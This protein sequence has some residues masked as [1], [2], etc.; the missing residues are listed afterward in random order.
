M[1][2]FQW[3]SDIHSTGIDDIDAQH[4]KLFDS[5][6]NLFDSINYNPIASRI[7][8]LLNTLI[9]DCR[10]YFEVKE[11]LMLDYR[12]PDID[13]HRNLNITFTEIILDFVDHCRNKRFST[14]LDTLEFLS[15]WYLNNILQAYQRYSNF[16]VLQNT[17]E[18][19]VLCH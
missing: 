7:N 4:K 1:N 12:Y 6:S 17:P 14:A 5:L 8:P 11:Q 18:P 15:R 13:A 19:S 10:T 2:L 3:N 16:I 9:L